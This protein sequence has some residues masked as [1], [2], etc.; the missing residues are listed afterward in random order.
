MNIALTLDEQYPSSSSSEIENQ[1]ADRLLS[2]AEHIQAV[3][4]RLKGVRRSPD[5]VA[6]ICIIWVRLKTPGQGV[7]VSEQRS[8]V[9]EVLNQALQQATRSI[10]NTIKRT[11]PKNSS[12]R[13]VMESA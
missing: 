5:S 13:P 12:F 6:L 1:V 2:F 3:K 4:I 10:E 7:I 11:R 9:S 8:S